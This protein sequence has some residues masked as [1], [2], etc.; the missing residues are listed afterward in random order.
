MKYALLS[1]VLMGLI[2]GSSTADVND[3]SGGVLISHHPPE[4]CGTYEPSQ[5]C[6]VYEERGWGIA[7][8]EEQVNRIDAVTYS[9]AT[10]FI[11][12]AFCED[13]QFCTVVFG[14][15]EYEMGIWGFDT[16]SVFSC[17]PGGDGSR[18]L[19]LPTPKWPGPGEGTALTSTSGSWKGNHRAI[20]VIS[21]YA[22]GY[23]GAS[24]I[25]PLAVN[26]QKRVGTFTNCDIVPVDFPIAA[27]GGMGINTDGVYVEPEC[28]TGVE[29]VELPENAE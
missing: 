29:D 6:D 15:G 9:Y 20:Y 16:A 4:C 21:G 23:D 26:P 28:G 14:L 17:G 5:W 13:K 11:I 22:Y 3:L 18:C 7:T 27:Y 19:E 2:A 24:G 25:L 1:F 10:W 12:A 8:P